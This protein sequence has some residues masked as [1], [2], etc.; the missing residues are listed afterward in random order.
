MRVEEAFLDAPQSVRKLAARTPEAIVK[1]GPAGRPSSYDARKREFRIAPDADVAEILHE[2]FHH[3]DHSQTRL[4]FQT[5]STDRGTILGEAISNEI[6]RFGTLGKTGRKSLA[7]RIRGDL[8]LE[9]MLGAISLNEVGRGHA[10]EYWASHGQ[11]ESRGVRKCRFDVLNW[12]MGS[13]KER[14]A[15]IGSRV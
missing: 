15:G 8:N 12:T 7:A 3:I 5:V 1:E 6:E 4:P 11:S 14:F 13:R 2:Y 9:D 10:R